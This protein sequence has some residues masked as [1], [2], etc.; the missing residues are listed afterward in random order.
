MISTNSTTP[1]PE[2]LAAWKARVNSRSKTNTSSPKI[3]PVFFK[4]S[5]NTWTLSLRDSTKP[6][7]VLTE[8]S[9]EC[10]RSGQSLQL[11]QLWLM[12]WKLERTRENYPPWE[13]PM[14]EF[15]AR[16][17]QSK[18]L[19]SL[20]PSSS[21]SKLPTSSSGFLLWRKSDWIG[22]VPFGRS[23]AAKMTQILS[24]KLIRIAPETSSF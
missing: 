15:V 13:T 8:R 19:W 7:I 22:T 3:T 16:A 21:K 4:C 17:C 23:T 24:A 1:A 2:G 5:D 14:L 6:K 11:C 18:N 20:A 12:R 10:L 9:N